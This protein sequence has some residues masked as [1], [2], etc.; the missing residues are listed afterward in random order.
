MYEQ[1]TT[2]SR[3]VGVVRDYRYTP[4]QVEAATLLEYYEVVP[5]CKWNPGIL[6][7]TRNEIRLQMGILKIILTSILYG[8]SKILMSIAHL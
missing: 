1:A 7:R 3:V 6:S 8:K 5:I 2:S 4:S